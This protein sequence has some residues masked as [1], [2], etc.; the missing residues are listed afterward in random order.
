MHFINRIKMYC[1]CVKLKINNINIHDIYILSS[2]WWY[3]A[4]WN[5]K[6]LFF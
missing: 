6:V 3:I 1:I 2:F 5:A 4:I